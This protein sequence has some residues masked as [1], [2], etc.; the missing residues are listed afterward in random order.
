MLELGVLL[1]EDNPSVLPET[2][3]TLTNI[4]CA[5]Y[6]ADYPKKRTGSVRCTL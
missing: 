1:V 6:D 4:G 5:I 2:Q 3:R